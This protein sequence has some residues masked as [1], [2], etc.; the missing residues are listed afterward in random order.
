MWNFLDLPSTILASNCR[1]CKTQSP[2]QGLGKCSTLHNMPKRFLPC[3]GRWFAPHAS[4]SPNL[5]WNCPFWNC[6]V[7]SW[8]A[9]LW[10]LDEMS[11]SV[12]KILWSSRC[13]GCWPLMRW[14]R[15]WARDLHW[16]SLRARKRDCW[17]LK[18]KGFEQK[19][20]VIPKW[21]GH[22]RRA[23]PTAILKVR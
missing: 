21:G 22:T 2:I 6:C 23:H 12:E 14:L 15:W 20:V 16:D 13:F 19:W 4:A 3:T 1:D 11:G 8:R 10:K 18:W 9:R 5:P 7:D 17:S